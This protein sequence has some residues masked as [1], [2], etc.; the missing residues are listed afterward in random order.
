M[1]SFSQESPAKNSF[2]PDLSTMEE[3]LV[4]GSQDTGVSIDEIMDSSSGS[5]MDKVS[6]PS[7]S[8]GSP[9]NTDNSTDAIWSLISLC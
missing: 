2:D 9:V 5:E 7:S 3:L 6:M 4:L 8:N 1:L